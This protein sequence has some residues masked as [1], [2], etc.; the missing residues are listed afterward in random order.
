[1]AGL[2]YQPAI[3]SRAEWRGDLSGIRLQKLSLRAQRSNLIFTFFEERKRAA[4]KS[5]AWKHGSQGLVRYSISL[6]LRN[7]WMHSPHSLFDFTF[8]EERMGG[9]LEDW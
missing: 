6:F 1:L 5:A 7:E 8:F 2:A 9:R 4:A 3:Y